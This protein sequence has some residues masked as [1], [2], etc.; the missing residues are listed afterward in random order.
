MTG[1]DGGAISMRIDALI[2][3][4]RGPLRE[5]QLQYAV[6]WDALQSANL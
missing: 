5:I 6:L 4:Y 1:A 2:R 3:I